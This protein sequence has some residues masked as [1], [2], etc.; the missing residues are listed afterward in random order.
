M[1]HVETRSPIAFLDLKA[2]NATHQEAIRRA[3]ERVLQS[4][5]YILGNELETFEQRFAAYCGTRYCLGVANG[6]DALTLILK[7]YGFPPGSEVIVPAHT[8][9]ASLLAVSNAGLQPVL[10]EPDRQ[11]YLIHPARVQAAIT[12]RTKAIMVVHLYGKCCA[13]APLTKLARQYGLKVI[14]DAAQAHGAMHQNRKAGNLGDAAGFSF[15]PVKNLGALG[16]GG[17]IITNDP[18][19]ADRLG[20]LRNYGSRTKYVHDY[21]GYN[22]RLDEI[23]AAILTEK[24]P[25]LDAENN[26]RRQLARRYVDGIRHPNVGLPPADTLDEDSW[27]LFVIRHPA[28]QKLI[29]YLSANGIQTAVHYPVPPHQQ[30]AYADLQPLPLPITERLHQEVISLPLNTALRDEEVDWIIERLN[31]APV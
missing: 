8:F 6:L 30:T 9:I 24:L 7:A 1:K 16:D 14:E 19:L 22:S 15:Y 26:R 28:R 23:Q 17:A 29:D 21:P 18:V 11:T 3:T 2:I 31:Q 4:G 13:M 25:F 5:W 10:V 20:Y 12:A 27:H